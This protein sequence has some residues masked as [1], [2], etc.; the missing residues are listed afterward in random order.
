MADDAATHH[1]EALQQDLLDLVGFKVNEDGKLQHVMDDDEF[2]QS[3]MPTVFKLMQATALRVL[4]DNPDRSDVAEIS[5]TFE[6]DYPID[7]IRLYRPPAQVPD[8]ES[9]LAWI[10]QGIMSA[11]RLK[12]P[13]I[14]ALSI[15]TRLA[16]HVRLDGRTRKVIPAPYWASFDAMSEAEREAFQAKLFAPVEIKVSGAAYR[17]LIYPLMLDLDAGRGWFTLKLECAS[18]LAAHLTFSDKENDGDT[19]HRIPSQAPITLADG[20]TLVDA[21][22]QTV[23]AELRD[24]G[25]LADEVLALFDNMKGPDGNR[26]YP[27][28]FAPTK[29]DRQSYE[30]VNHG[31]ELRF[32]TSIEKLKTREQL[33]A[34]E[35]DEL[36]GNLSRPP[37]AYSDDELADIGLRRKPVAGKELADYPLALSGKQKQV[38]RD[39]A[40]ERGFIEFDKHKRPA[41]YKRVKDRRGQPIEV[42]LS[43]NDLSRHFFEDDRKNERGKLNRQKQDIERKRRQLNMFGDTFDADLAQIDKRLN[44]LKIGERAKVVMRVL[45]GQ[46]SLYGV[47]RVTLPAKAFKGLFWGAWRGDENNLPQNWKQHI[48]A[49]LDALQSLRVRLHAKRQRDG[50]GNLVNID[51]FSPAIGQYVYVSAGHGGHG[52]GYYIIDLQ[53]VFIGCMKVF[54]LDASKR[55][56]NASLTGSHHPV[57]DEVTQYDFDQKLD[58]DERKTLDYRKD[59]SGI[60]FYSKSEKLTPEQTNIH[61][62]LEREITLNKDTANRKA[63]KARSN[64]ED[65][66]APRLY[67]SSWCPLLPSGQ[68]FV[69]A[70]GHFRKNAEAGRSLGG[71]KSNTG[72]TDGIIAE[73]GYEQKPGRAHAQRGEIVE[74]TLEDLKAVAV[75]YLGGHIFGKLKARD[76]TDGEAGDQWLHFADF[77]TLP[78]KTLRDRLKIFAFLPPDWDERRKKKFEGKTGYKVTASPQ[79]ALAAYNAPPAMPAPDKTATTAAGGLSPNDGSTISPGSPIKYRLWG[80]M[81]KRKLKN[82]DIARIFGVSKMAVSQ[83]LYGMKEGQDDPSKA[84]RIPDDLAALMERWVDAGQEPTQAELDGLASRKRSP[85][86][87]KAS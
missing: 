59:H 19:W 57:L 69:G 29:I 34:E 41:L 79:A 52:D 6:I 44:T 7:E 18:N 62:W 77:Q 4:Q 35:L 9:R 51:G 75:D 82:V 28:P 46:Q 14:D 20:S 85:A 74:R 72:H 54:A 2:V 21:Q 65:A 16:A 3:I 33:E 70:L 24:G 45:L 53:D 42:W 71:T 61:R 56:K 36:A 30:F 37:A 40:G 32:P 47:S 22:G 12:G 10:A 8:D 11:A 81:K 60:D 63:M 78:E 31:P 13:V 76:R 73:A 15:T 66:N 38:V 83:W 80:A 84:R 64:A 49:V 43:L 39:R 55:K 86:R 26:I 67:D 87:R 5:K 58:K 48:N 17:L 68:A 23:V 27:V 25:D 50:D 1:T